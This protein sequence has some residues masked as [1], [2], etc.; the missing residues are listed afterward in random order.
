M[1]LSIIIPVYNEEKT[2]KDVL[3]LI[4]NLKLI[5]NF[6]K[7]I[8]VVNDCSKDN[9]EQII[10][11]YIKNNPQHTIKYVKHETNQGKGRGVRNGIKE[12]TGDYI[13][14]QDA[15]FEYDP[16]DINLILEKFNDDNVEVVFG[17]R[18]LKERMLGRSKP[19]KGKHPDSYVWAYLGGIFVTGV[20]NFIHGTKLTDT[21]TC[22]KCFKAE[23][24][25]SFEIESKDFAWETEITVKLIKRGIEIHEIP[26]SYRPRK[27][28]EGK[29]IKASDGIKVT[30]AILRHTYLRR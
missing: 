24:L 8:I 12:A 22:Y 3:E 25:K 18:V 11:D 30:A 17:S 29:K 13:I 7:E 5:N 14:I 9:S 4:T 19:F 16:E 27:T 15:D 1:T 26:I 23:L 10:L 21:P 6:E 28:T 2:I 20:V